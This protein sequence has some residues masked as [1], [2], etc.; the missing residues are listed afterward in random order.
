MV[1]SGR[2]AQTVSAIASAEVRARWPSISRRIWSRGFGEIGLLVE[3]RAEAQ[4]PDGPPTLWSCPP[5]PREGICRGKSAA[6]PLPAAGA[7]VVT[8]RAR[9]ISRSSSETRGFATANPYI[10][11]VSYARPGSMAPSWARS[12]IL[13]SMPPPKPVRVPVG[14]DDAVTG[15]DSGIRVGGIAQPTARA[16]DG[17]AEQRCDP[18]VTARLPVWDRQQR[19]PDALLPVTALD[20][21]LKFERRSARAIVVLGESGSNDLRRPIVIPDRGPAVAPQGCLD[22][23]RRVSQR[24]TRRRT[25]GHPRS[26]RHAVARPANPSWQGIAFP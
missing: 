19:L 11:C 2:A 20:R 23:S 5:N 24:R 4:T 17:I 14:A 9:C 3:L 15:D 25:G 13:A 7:A 16:F 26:P 1:Y 6:D 8:G 18:A 12:W 10:Y 21:Q 22:L